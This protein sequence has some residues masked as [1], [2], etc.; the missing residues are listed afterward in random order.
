MVCV[1]Q[2]CPTSFPMCGGGRVGKGR[3]HQVHI[4]PACLVRWLE[5]AQS[6]HFEE[7]LCIVKLSNKA[8]IGRLGYAV[9]TMHWTW[10]PER[11]PN[12]GTACLVKCK[13]PLLSQP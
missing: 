8:F 7:I 1:D 6:E 11:L 10:R 9:H 4:F 12:V 3:H 2:F 5:E 13:L